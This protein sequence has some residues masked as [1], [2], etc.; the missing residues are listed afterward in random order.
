MPASEGRTLLE[1]L[2]AWASRLELDDVP[3]RVVAYA[4]SQVLSQLAA[5]RAG[6]MHPLGTLVSAAF[7]SP[8]Q[9]DPA[10][11]ACA[12]AGLTPWLY[13][14]DTSYA[15]HLSNSTVTVPLSYARVHRLDGRALLRAVIA[16]NEC[17]A[18]ITAAVTL[19]PFRGQNSPHTHLAGAIAGR[20]SSE[21]APAELWANAFGIAFSLPP[22]PSL[23]G[24]ISSDARVLSALSPVRSGLDACDAALG[25]L[26]GPPSVLEHSD[27]FLQRFATVPVPEAVVAGLGSLWH[28]ETLSF[29]LQPGG[30]VHDAAVD[31]AR[32]I[33]R[34]AGPVDPATVDEIVVQTSLYTV[35][36]DQ[37]A[38]DYLAGPRSPIGALMFSASY[39]VA[40]ALLAGGLTTSDFTHPRVDDPRR[41]ELAAKVRVEQDD[42]MTRASFR[43]E[44]P[45][46]QALR[47]AGD[48][49]IPW[50][51]KLGGR[52]LV[53][54]VGPL[55]APSTSFEHA[56]KVRPARVSVR[57]TDGRTVDHQVWSASGSAGAVTRSTHERLVRDKFLSTDGSKEI[58]DIAADLA[59]A[60][61][62][63]VA[64]M[65]ASA[66]D[67]TR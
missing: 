17:A 63:D 26:R 62:D 47:L 14:D 64:L 22:W 65:C 39:L 18:R 51:E 40:T 29:E 3:D 41:W 42:G 25:G 9:P 67:L 24:F 6:L 45:F 21:R 54:L 1:E 8:L 16:A 58:A 66:L 11:A 33:H 59:H 49:A 27:G 55:P 52:W 15:G 50:L 10:R 19:G 44:V 37:K 32:E 43:C 57:F 38:A 12:L 28:T 56:E 34:R 61:A 5:A 31:C 53:D 20:M 23:H 4:Q 13:F 48:R 30:P 60:D 35:L 46:G 36:V 7:G 2:C